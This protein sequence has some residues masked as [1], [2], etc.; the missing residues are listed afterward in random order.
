VRAKQKKENTHILSQQLEGWDPLRSAIAS[1]NGYRYQLLYLLTE[2]LELLS[3]SNEV[4]LG[5]EEGQEDV[6]LW[7]K[8]KTQARFLQLKY[9]SN[10]LGLDATFEKVFLATFDLY[11]RKEELQGLN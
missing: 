4:W 7:N 2:L 9:Y 11:R 6:D 10:P 3:S 1:A 8:E 5:C